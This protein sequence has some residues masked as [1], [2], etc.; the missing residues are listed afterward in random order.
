VAQ[1][2]VDHILILDEDEMGSFKNI[3][4]NNPKAKSLKKRKNKPQKRKR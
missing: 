4:Q 3:G 2:I 1:I